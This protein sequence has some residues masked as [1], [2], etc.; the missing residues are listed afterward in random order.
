MSSKGLLKRLSLSAVVMFVFVGLSAT[1]V[2]AHVT[3]KPGEVPTSTYQVFTVSVPNEKEIPTTSV[4]VEVPENITNV[5]PTKKAGWEIEVSRN[6]E[7]VSSITWKGGE[8]PDGLRDEFTFSAKTPAEAGSVNW[9][10]YQTY[11]DGTVVAWDQAETGDGHGDENKGPFSVT[12]I[13][14]QTQNE[15]VNN[16]EVSEAN[17]K[18][19]RANYIAIAA[20]VVALIAIFFAT[21][22]NRS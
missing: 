21:R 22:K 15:T 7:N 14:A 13:V 20:V 5:T 8:V 12:S 17:A 9:K 11:S 18:A 4:R 19:D 6:G 16:K 2:S 1:S 10:A 3:V